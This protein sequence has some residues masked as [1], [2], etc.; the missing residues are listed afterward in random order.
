M[1]KTYYFLTVLLDYIDWTGMTVFVVVISNWVIQHFTLQGKLRMEKRVKS[2]HRYS[3]LIRSLWNCTTINN[4]ESRLIGGEW[5]G[6]KYSPRKNTN[7]KLIDKMKIWIFV[8]P[9]SPRVFRPENCNY[10]IGMDHS[11]EL[12][13]IC[14]FRLVRFY[15]D[16]VSNCRIITSLFNWVHINLRTCPPHRPITI[17]TTRVLAF[18][19]HL[20]RGS[21]SFQTY[22][23][24]SIALPGLIRTRAQDL[25]LY[26]PVSALKGISL[27]LRW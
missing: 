27:N 26:T 22:P 3:T 17:T 13:R 12:N 24:R 6:F 2:P 11:I 19:H 10:A 23:P 15:A 8:G 5:E 21:V 9:L 18:S 1:K 25:S 7:R 4:S 16:Y 14:C 20:S